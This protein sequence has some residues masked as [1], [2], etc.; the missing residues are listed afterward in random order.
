MTAV[1]LVLHASRVRHPEWCSLY[2]QSVEDAIYDI[3]SERAFVR[4]ES[5]VRVGTG[6]DDIA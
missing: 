5:G 3:Q 6:C 4:R 2:D 1:R